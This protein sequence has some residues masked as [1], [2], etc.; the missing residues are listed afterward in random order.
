[1][2]MRKTTQEEQSTSE[3]VERKLVA[4]GDQLGLLIGTVRAKAE[5]WLDRTVLTTGRG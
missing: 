5:G 4:L 2:T 3:L 1:M